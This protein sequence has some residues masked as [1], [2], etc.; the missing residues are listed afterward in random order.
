MS[1]SMMLGLPSKGAIAEP[2]L[3]FLRD[4]G[5]RVHKPNERQYTGSIPAVPGLGVLF[6]RVKDVLY[7]VSDGTVQLGITGYDVVQE[8]PHPDLVVIHPALDYGHCRLVVAVPESWVDVESM[9]DLREVANDLRRDQQRDLRVATTY[10]HLTRQFLHSVGIHHFTLVRAEGAI[11]AA[12]TIGYADVIVDLVQTGTTLRENHL[13]PLEDGTIVESQACLVGNVHALRSDPKVLGA[14]QMLLEYFDAAL[15][16]K[17]YRQLTV[18]I[19]GHSPQDIAQKIASNPLTKGLQGPTIAPIY[20]L[21]EPTE[22]Y[23][24]TINI[25]AQDVLRAVNDLRALGSSQ[26]VVSPVNFVF[27]SESPNFAHLKR[28]LEQ[29]PREA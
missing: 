18:N 5:L 2:T 23:T 3:N 19:R 25:L 28:M 13:K 8:N 4:C 1:K 15:Q 17:R 10:S 26:V 20:G 7:K 27:Q 21:G 11:E 14:A 24:V 29:P 12:P 16:G 6:Q 22:W 9:D